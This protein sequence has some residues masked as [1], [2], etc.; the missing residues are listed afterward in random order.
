MCFDND[1]P[2]NKASSSMYYELS[3]LGVQVIEYNISGNCKDP[4]ELL[5]SN[6]KKLEEYIKSAKMRLRKQYA[7]SKD[8][9]TASEL[10]DEDVEPPTWIVRDVLP[11]GLAMLCAP[12]KIESLG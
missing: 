11:T 10:Q 1:E 7:T 12:S 6:H 5:M 2:G 4:N 3:N 8:S 9:F